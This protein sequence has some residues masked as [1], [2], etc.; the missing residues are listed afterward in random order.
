MSGPSLLFS[1][2]LEV[3]ASTIGRER[4]EGGRKEGRREGGA[5]PWEEVKLPL[6]TDDMIIYVENPREA[7]RKLLEQMSLVN[8]QDTRS[9]H[10]NKLYFYVLAT[11]RNFKIPFRASLVVQWL[12]ILLPVQGTRVRAMIWEDLTCRG[13]TG[14]VSH[15]Y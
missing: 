2:I 12:R 5:F 13:A 1:I 14:P 9:I 15:N 3:L 10:K 4:W 11:I 6:F 8:W 7:T